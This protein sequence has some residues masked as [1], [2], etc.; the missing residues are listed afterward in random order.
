MNNIILKILGLLLAGGI[1]S[2]ATYQYV[3]NTD[4]AKV[5]TESLISGD[6]KCSI[7]NTVD[8]AF[9]K[10]TTKSTLYSSGENIKTESEI[11][12]G[13]TIMKS[14]ILIKDNVTYMWSSASLK[15]GVKVPSKTGESLA[16]S[17]RKSIEKIYTNCADWSV[18]KSVF[19][20][21]LGIDFK[22]A[23]I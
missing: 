6:K 5:I 3:K 2:G 12:T 18:E 19:E 23:A 8:S 21:P 4:V 9:G 7:S 20:L 10:I 11:N 16:D 1:I 13:G 22:E 17:Y 15:V 14:S